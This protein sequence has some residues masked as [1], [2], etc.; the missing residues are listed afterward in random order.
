VGKPRNGHGSQGIMLLPDSE[1]LQE[2]ISSQPQNYCLQQYIAGP[3]FTIG[4]LYDSQGVMQD[5]VAME[6]TLEGGRTVK[7]R[8]VD[9]PDMRQFISK[10]GERVPGIGA[11]N[12]QLRWHDDDGPMVFEINARLSGSTDMRVAVGCNDPLRLVRHFGRGEPIARSCPSSATVRRN[13]S[14]LQVESC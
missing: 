9:D 4:F 6:R 10:F 5:A 1:A 7:G 3:E 13:G 2:F 11:V 8:V 12:A 14:E